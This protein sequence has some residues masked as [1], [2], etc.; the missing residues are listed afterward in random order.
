[1]SRGWSQCRLLFAV[2]FQ[3]L[4]EIL[5]LSEAGQEHVRLLLLV[6][7]G[8]GGIG[9]H[10]LLARGHQRTVFKYFSRCLS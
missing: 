1:M 7:L 4:G 6:F 8:G 3:D 5:L 10:V 9:V 2:F